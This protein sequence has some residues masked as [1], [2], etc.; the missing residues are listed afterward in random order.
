MT[1]T[2]YTFND[3]ICAQLRTENFCKHFLKVLHHSLKYSSNIS[4]ISL[5]SLEVGI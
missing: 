3:R 1:Y 5:I 2:P 4:Q